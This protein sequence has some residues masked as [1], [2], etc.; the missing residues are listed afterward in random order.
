MISYGK[1]NQFRQTVKTII[2]QIRYVGLDDNDKAVYDPNIKL[3]VVQFF[4]T[5]KLHGTNASIVMRN[6]E[7]TYQSKNNELNRNKDNAGFCNA[8]ED[9]EHSTG[10]I[11]NLFNLIDIDD[12]VTIF[13][14]WAGKGVQG[15]VG[16]SKLDKAFYIFAIKVGEG[17]DARNLDMTWYGSIDSPEN[18]VFNL[19]DTTMF[20]VYEIDVDLENPID[21]TSEL[22]ELTLEVEKEC[23]VAY[24]FD[25]SGIGEGIVWVSDESHGVG[26]HRFKVKGE[27]HSDTKVKKLV[28]VDPQVMADIKEF[29]DR[30]CTDHRLEKG[31]D[32][33]LENQVI[34]DIS[35]T[36]KFVKWA[37]ND[38][39]SEEID[40]IIASDLDRKYLPSSIAKAAST[41]YR[42]Y[43]NRT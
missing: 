29:V 40:T 23:P 38:V 33:L 36:G 24:R 2:S 3:P 11:S 37:T 31:I 30:T 12:T 39:M 25:E 9:L 43:I 41:W 10:A 13:G 5:I 34:I 17:E 19:W 6:G 14:E 42:S 26:N 28:T 27:K 16:V 7:L 1:T 21:C 22:E 20:P 18:R 4:G 35:S 8:M 32:Y 15:G